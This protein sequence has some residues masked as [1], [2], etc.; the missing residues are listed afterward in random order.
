MNDIVRK[1]KKENDMVFTTDKIAKTQ[2]ERVGN[3]RVESLIFHLE[4]EIIFCPYLWQ[5]GR[6]KF[7][8]L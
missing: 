2:K 8:R 4:S 5:L 1:I 3:Q 7:S 6:Y